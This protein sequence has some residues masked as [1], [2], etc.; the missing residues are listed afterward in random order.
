MP[1][2]LT[3]SKIYLFSNFSLYTGFLQHSIIFQFTLENIIHHLDY[4][5]SILRLWTL[6][7]IVYHF[8]YF[9]HQKYTLQKIVKGNHSQHLRNKKN[10][11]IVKDKIWLPWLRESLQI[12][13]YYNCFALTNKSLTI[14]QCVICYCH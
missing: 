9:V 4:L 7:L 6:S 2:K 3:E 13:I 11:K 1:F 5:V 14:H 12:F 10:I 8:F